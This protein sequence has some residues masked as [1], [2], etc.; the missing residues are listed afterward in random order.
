MQAFAIDMDVTRLLLGSRGYGKTD[1]CTI[2]GVAYKQY[3]AWFDGLG[4][5]EHTVLIITNLN[6]ETVRSLKRSCS[7]REEWS[8]TR[9]GE[10]I[11]NSSGPDLSVRTIRLRL[12]QSKHQ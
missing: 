5:S 4:L 3:C 6:R 11:S 9:Q 1:F 8:A 12:L 7:D 2:M 10:C